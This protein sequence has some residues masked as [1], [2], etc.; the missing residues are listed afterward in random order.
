MKL[1]LRTCPYRGHGSLSLAAA[2]GLA[3]SRASCRPIAS[4]IRRMRGSSDSP[5]HDPL[6][7]AGQGPFISSSAAIPALPREVHRTK[8]N[9]EAQ[10]GSQKVG[11]S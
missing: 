7:L 3:C 9:E 1:E 8:N 11:L 10:S 4:A 2:G 6:S 5:E